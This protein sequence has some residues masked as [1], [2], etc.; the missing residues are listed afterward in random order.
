MERVLS[1]GGKQNW[2][3]REPAVLVL[4]ASG[5]LPDLKKQRVP[6]DARDGEREYG[7]LINFNPGSK[8]SKRAC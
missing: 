1:P 4:P 6:G 5:A 2:V 3:G 7:V 8:R